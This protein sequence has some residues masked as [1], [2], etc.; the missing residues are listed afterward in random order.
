MDEGAA[1][2]Y[3]MEKSLRASLHTFAMDSIVSPP[4]EDHGIDLVSKI[5]FEY[6][7]LHMLC[8]TI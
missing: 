8:Q 3:K 1:V 5:S 7:N 2:I 4:D 6:V